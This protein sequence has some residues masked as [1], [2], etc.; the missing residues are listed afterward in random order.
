MDQE[1]SF[2]DEE[3][4]FFKRFPENQQDQI[5]ALVNY[6]TLMGLTGKDLVSIGGK[7]DRLNAS[8]EY[9]RN[10]QMIADMKPLPVGKDKN[11]RTDRFKIK[12]VDG[13]YVFEKKYSSDWRITSSKTK[14]SKTVSTDSYSY[15]LGKNHNWDKRSYMSILLDVANGKVLLDF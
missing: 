12:A 2:F 5:R 15:Q 10:K 13:S 9:A 4:L 7:L 14:V 1:P 6:V 8:R 11:L 3:Q